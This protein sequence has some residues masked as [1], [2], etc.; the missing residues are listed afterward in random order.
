MKVGIQ[1]CF[2]KNTLVAFSFFM[3][4]MLVSTQLNAVE[5]HSEKAL[6]LGYFPIIS[7]VALFKRFGPLRDYL[8]EELGRPVI[9]KT[10]KNFPTFVKRTDKREYDIVVTAPHFAVRAADS[11]KY[12]VRASLTASVQ[13]LVVVRKDSSITNVS[14]LVGKKVSTPPAKALMTM[15]GVQHFLDAGLKGNQAPKYKPFTSHNAAN[16]AVIG[17]EVDAAIASSNIIKKA[18]KQGAP[19]KI[20][21][22]GLKLPNMATLVA[23]DRD[24]DIGNAL[25]QALVKMK[26]TVKGKAA[27]KKI[28]F[29][30]YRQVSAK[31]YEPARPYMVQGVAKFGLKK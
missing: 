12:I 6:T 4:L 17:R 14:Q 5:K 30:G 9:M 10:A 11:G 26:K 18:I 29:P 19:L 20:I 27:L 24:K 31:D 23:T 8:A 22:R 3:G 21:S 28:A 25:V 1:Q 16:E 7:T 13:Q 2:E 15:M